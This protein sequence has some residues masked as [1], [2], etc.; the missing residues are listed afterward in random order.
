M[1]SNMYCFMEVKDRNN[2]WQLVKYLENM[3]YNENGHEQENFGEDYYKIQYPFELK[4]IISVGCEIRDELRWRTIN[5]RPLPDDISTELAN[6]MESKAKSENG[7]II[8]S[9]YNTHYYCISISELYE[10]YE[11]RYTSWKDLLNRNIE[12][13]KNNFLISRIEDAKNEIIRTIKG[14][15]DYIEKSEKPQE[16]NGPYCYEDSFD[17]AVGEGLESLMELREQINALR[18]YAVAYSGDDFIDEDHIRIY[19]FY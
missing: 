11:K 2:N 15:T 3:K 8:E 17:F 9:Y 18:S 12:Y 1:S 5:S 19:C 16:E 6:V 13:R 14:N 4:R 10:L 7:S